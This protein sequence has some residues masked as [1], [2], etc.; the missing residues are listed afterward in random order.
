[1]NEAH[2]DAVSRLMSQILII[3]I[4]TVRLQRSGA[5][6][7]M[8]V[9]I[10]NCV[11]E[12][13]QLIE[14]LPSSALVAYRDATRGLAT[15]RGANCRS[16]ASGHT[17]FGCSGTCREFAVELVERTAA[18]SGI[19]P[20][21][22]ERPSICPQSMSGMTHDPRAAIIVSAVCDRSA[23]PLRQQV[24]DQIPCVSPDPARYGRSRRVDG[25]MRIV[26]AMQNSGQPHGTAFR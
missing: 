4:Y 16:T 10:C 17:G 6:G 3:L 18:H 15:V 7:S 21:L 9:C 11:T 23:V 12:N 5:E 19:S 24:N 26:L 22:P 14:E 13:R 25:N 1:M 2:C 20:S 8:Y